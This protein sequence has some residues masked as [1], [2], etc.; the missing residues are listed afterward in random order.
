M[1]TIKPIPKSREEALNEVLGNPSTTVY[2]RGF[3]VSTAGDRTKDISIGIMDID[4]A[5][6]Q[7]IVQKIKPSII[8]DSE[9]L[10]VPVM[11]G[12]PERWYTVQEKGYLREYAGKLL[13]PCITITRDTIEANRGLGN[14]LDA[15]NPHNFLIFEVPYTKKNAYDRFD[16][17]N[18]RQPVKEYKAVVV[19]DYVTVTYDCSIYTNFIEQ[20]NKILEAFNY[21]SQAYWGEEG[22]FLFRAKIDNF[23]TNVNYTQN[24]ERT[25]VTTF[26]I[27]LNGY[28]IPDTI[29]RDLSYKKKFLSKAQIIFDMEVAGAQDIFNVSIGQTK[30]IISPIYKPVVNVA[31]VSNE[32]ANYLAVS[33]LKTVDVVSSNKLT[34]NNATILN[35]PPALPPTNKNNF[36]VLLGGQ[37]IP[38]NYIIYIQQAGSNVEV[39]VDN[40]GAGLPALNTLNN[41]FVVIGKFI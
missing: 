39:A 38:N 22:R 28:I 23:V 25:T 16:I 8:Q 20:N 29:N 40:V 2:N 18:N 27:V 5:V 37:V 10:E 41:D 31:N 21:A 33:V 36:T 14:K 3:D 34:I 6:M 15:N 24:N 13:T 11:F 9:R 19:P 30:P 7:Y 35:A 1:N 12:Y 4:N 17:L 32:V 26:K